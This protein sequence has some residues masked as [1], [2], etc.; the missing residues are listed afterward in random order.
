MNEKW[1]GVGIQMDLLNIEPPVKP[2]YEKQMTIKERFDMFHE[3][4]PQVARALASL[5]LQQKKRGL[6]K[7]GIQAPY[8]ILR[9]GQIISGSG[10]ESYKLPNEF[11][12]H[13]SR[14][15]MENMPALEGFFTVKELKSP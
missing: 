8:E 10:L 6:N 5:C 3:Q 2:D 14:L 13:Y 12:A 15:L 1:N 11:A 4:N 7:W 9:W